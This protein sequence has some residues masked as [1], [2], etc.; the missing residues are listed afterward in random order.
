MNHK[1]WNILTKTMLNP[2]ALV[3]TGKTGDTARLAGGQQFLAGLT[4]WQTTSRCATSG[5]DDQ[6][7]R[8]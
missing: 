6:E 3:K 4:A 5:R 8:P 1:K 7:T 2:A